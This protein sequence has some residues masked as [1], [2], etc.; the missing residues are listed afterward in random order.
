MNQAE[1]RS[2]ATSSLS[3][4][5]PDDPR[6]IQAMEEY[7]TALDAGRK[8]DRQAFLARHADL[9]GV[10]AGCLDGLEFM[11][12]AAPQLHEGAGEEA[13]ATATAVLAGTPPG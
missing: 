1:D 11:Q 12:T 5:A 4:P 13:A 7:Q 3:G 9:A 10:L 6:V 8:L 2:L